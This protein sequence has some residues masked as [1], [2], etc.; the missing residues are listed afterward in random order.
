M[1]NII[2][3]NLVSRSYSCK[4]FL[5]AIFRIPK[6]PCIFYN[7]RLKNQEKQPRK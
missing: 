6:N 5:E 3:K 2:I 1:E 4:N 7:Y